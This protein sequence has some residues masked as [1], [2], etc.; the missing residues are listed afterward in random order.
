VP[1]VPRT[2]SSVARD[3]LIDVRTADVDGDGDVDVVGSSLGDTTLRWYD[4]DGAYPPAFTARTIRASL[5]GISYVDVG[6][7]DGDG[8]VDVVVASRDDSRVTVHVNDGTRPPSFD[9]MAINNSSFIL[10][11]FACFGDVDGDG[12]MDVLASFSD[13]LVWFENLSNQ[14]R[15]AAFGPGRVIASSLTSQLPFGVTVADLDRDGDADLLHAWLDGDRVVWFPSNGGAPPTFAA[16]VSVA[17]PNG[18]RP[19][20]LAADI[21]S[22]GAIDV[23]MCSDTDNRFA[24]HFASATTPP[25]FSPLV[26]NTTF[27]HPH[28]VDVAD[29]DGDGDLDVVGSAFT[30]NTVVWFD[31][32]NE[33]P[34]PTFVTRVIAQAIPA[35]SGSRRAHSADVDNDDDV[36]VITVSHSSALVTLLENTLPVNRSRF[37]VSF[38][39]ALGRA[40]RQ[41][42]VHVHG[43]AAG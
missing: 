20:P 19:R 9:M 28:D 39:P 10:P 23:V 31:N 12:D 40:Q 5:A 13:S 27:R 6:D 17:T 42:C 18:P 25:V 32:N 26:L 2:L 34:S 15:L 21:N 37:R 41:L 35:L 33:W 36:D 14:S 11:T 1:F 30:E 22:D 24:V 8:D 16:A 3:P 7:V 29:F 43:G 38:P 4:S